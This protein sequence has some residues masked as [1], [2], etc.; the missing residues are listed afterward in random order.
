MFCWIR[1]RGDKIVNPVIL[2]RTI[3]FIHPRQISSFGRGMKQDPDTWLHPL[4]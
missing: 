4:A 3:S 1:W 2:L